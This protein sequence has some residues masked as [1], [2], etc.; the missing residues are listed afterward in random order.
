MANTL[1]PLIET[2][3]PRWDILAE[4]VMIGSLAVDLDVISGAIAEKSLYGDS[5]TFFALTYPTAALR[6]I[7][8]LIFERIT[9]KNPHGKGVFLLGTALGG[10]KSH[11][12]AALYHLA[13]ISGKDIPPIAK[14][15]LGDLSL[16]EIRV[17]ILTQNSAAGGTKPPKTLWGEIAKQLDQMKI[18]KDYDERLQAPSKDALR[19]LL[20][21][22][23][24][25]ILIDEMTSYLIRASAIPVGESSLAVQTRAF[26]QDLEEVVDQLPNT[27]LVISQL[28]EEF[29]PQHYKEIEKYAK[30]KRVARE[31]LEEHARHEV[32]VAAQLLLRKAEPVTP[33]RDDD[34]L[35]NILRRRVFESIDEKAAEKVAEEYFR[36]Y[37]TPGVRAAVPQSACNRDFE[38]K[39]K[40]TF[41][42]HP[43]FISLL[44]DKLGQ[45]PKF[46][47]TRG[48]LL[49]T[50]HAVR[51][52]YRESRKEA[53]IHPFHIDPRDIEIREELSKRVF[54]DTKLDNAMVTEFVDGP[55]ARSRAGIIDDTFGS[56]LGTRLATSILIESALITHRG[57]QDPLVGAAESEIYLDSLIPGDDETRARQAL[58]DGILERSYHIEKVRDKLVF[59]GE[60]NL[61]RYI[62]DKAQHI[63]DF[64]VEKEIRVKLD[65]QVLKGSSIFDK[66]ICEATT[67]E[68]I[69]DRQK[70]R[71]IVL[72]PT[73]PWW[74]SADDAKPCRELLRLYEKKSQSGEPRRYK[75]S[76]IFLVPVSSEKEQLYSTIRRCLAIRSIKEDEGIMSSLTEEQKKKLEEDRTKSEG[77][78]ILRIGRSFGLMFYPGA[79]GSY[80]TP[81]LRPKRIS[82]SERDL[83][84]DPDTWKTGDSRM[85][86]LLTEMLRSEE[87][88]REESPFSPDWIASR[89]FRTDAGAETKKDSLKFHEI[90]AAFYEDTSLPFLYPRELIRRSIEE[91]VKSG[92]FAVLSGEKLYTPELY[93]EKRE[94]PTVHE[95]SEVVLHDSDRYQEL[96][97]QY[98]DLC[99]FPHAKCK[100]KSVQK[101]TAAPVA[102]EICPS[103]GRPKDECSCEIVHKGILLKDV[104]G[105]LMDEL[106]KRK[107]KARELFLEASKPLDVGLM[108]KMHTMFGGAQASAEIVEIR[109]NV[110]TQDKD[111]KTQ[112]VSLT[113]NKPS[114]FWALIKG[115][116]D[117][118]LSQISSGKASGDAHITLAIRMK[119]PADY[120]Q[121]EEILR[122]LNI[123]GSETVKVDLKVRPEVGP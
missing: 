15:M 29:E 104:S 1:P 20:Q 7:P 114:A 115:S 52:I 37:C 58:I 106:R 84:L 62:D 8:R 45:A 48:A 66:I 100:C 14:E 90:E 50:I 76:L 109:V 13:R 74:H 56:E 113:G 9:G 39:L 6:T 51:R 97:E 98:H 86:R 95:D 27:A 72:P 118:L 35:M 85:M 33:V 122:P 93:S 21:G 4:D 31:T 38:Q 11:V 61:N 107:L 92:S 43:K 108:L 112:E 96:L 59:R 32:G 18:M 117:S 24:V 26:L 119:A 2:C 54:D 57:P 81:V 28:P 103:C 64:E 79:E 78:S 105:V 60:V 80:R 53:M 46:M 83:G 67:P 5:N 89:I 116:V 88:L 49:L 34:E 42:F 70:L 47:Q 41:P 111:G 82:P 3:K 123:P 91:G 19:Q 101:P 99:G 40:R 55:D 65:T 63:S 94:L 10:G 25:L 23:P 17:V 44:R 102:P 68:D 87:K 73:D 110:R 30:G 22:K 71:L 121:A 16:P 75:N 69:E 36:Y 120:R 77:L 12:L